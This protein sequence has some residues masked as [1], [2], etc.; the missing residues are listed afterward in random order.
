MDR[1]EQIH[2]W[3]QEEIR[4]LK[5]VFPEYDVKVDYMTSISSYISVWVNLF[6]NGECVEFG[7]GETLT[8][9]I[10]KL[11]KKL[12]ECNCMP[13]LR[14]CEKHRKE[15]QKRKPYPKDIWGLM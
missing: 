4:Y 7:Y 13:G 14:I 6:K 5:S 9:A 15:M 1:T 8:E 12:E 10:N 3:I 11:R 2:Q